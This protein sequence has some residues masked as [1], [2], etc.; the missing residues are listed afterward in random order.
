M[1]IGTLLIGTN[2]TKGQLISKQ[3]CRA[4]TSPKKQTQD[5]CPGSLLLQGQYKRESIF[6]QKEDRL[7]FCINLEVVNFQGRNPMFVFLEKLWLNILV[8]RLT[9]LQKRFSY[10]W[11]RVWSNGIFR[12]CLDYLRSSKYIWV[13]LFF[14]TFP[15]KLSG[16]CK[17][18]CL[19]CLS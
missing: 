2:I 7:S 4:I 11:I 13:Y 16:R 1:S 8:S 9:D 18:P 19:C 17:P 3:N 12:L 10:L 5:F 14:P 15:L 6:L